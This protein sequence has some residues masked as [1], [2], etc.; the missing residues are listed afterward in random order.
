MRE[1]EAELVGTHGRACLLDVVAEHLPQRLVEQVRGGVVRH[2][3]EADAPRDDRLDAVAGRE[4]VT[5]E[6]EH[7][8][9]AEAV[10]LDELGADGRVVVELDPAVVGHLA[11]TGRIERRLPQLGEERAVAEILERVR[12]G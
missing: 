10:R 12:A 5:A 6:E 7:L 3:R 1:V 11:A 2:R 8:V 4:P 9:V